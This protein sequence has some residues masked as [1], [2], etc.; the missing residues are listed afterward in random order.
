MTISSTAIFGMLDING[1]LNVSQIGDSF[2]V[3]NPCNFFSDIKGRFFVV[4]KA[5]QEEKLF[6]VESNSF[7]DTR[8][9]TKSFENVK[10]IIAGTDGVSQNTQKWLQLK[11]ADFTDPVFRK[12]ISAIKHDTCDDKALCVIQILNDD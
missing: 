5:N 4:I 1:N 3:T 2:I 9:E 10:T 12:T 11:P 7:E 8:C 6:S